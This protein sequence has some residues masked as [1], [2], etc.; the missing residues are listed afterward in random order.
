MDFSELVEAIDKDDTSKI[1]SMLKE[2]M[3]RLVGFLL[4]HMDAGRP[5]AEDCAQETVITTLESIRSGDLRHTDQ[6]LS[7]MLSTS[8]NIYLNLIKKRK[9]PYFNDD[10]PDFGHQP[11]QLLSLLDEER[12]RVLEWCIRQLSEGYRGFIEYWFTYPDSDARAVAHHFDISVNNAWIR[13]HR[14]IKKL[15]KCCKEKI[16]L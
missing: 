7:F 14:I 16:S 15:S 13:K 10:L 4:I 5:D 3:P 2:L 11:Q 12:K 8:R 6:L 1:N 9:D